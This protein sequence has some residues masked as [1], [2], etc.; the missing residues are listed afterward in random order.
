MLSALHQLCK[1]RSLWG[2]GPQRKVVAEALPR[3]KEAGLGPRRHSGME[4]T[5]A[6]SAALLMTLILVSGL[7]TL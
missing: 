4:R 1:D 3:G 5:L 6:H 2:T 7:Q